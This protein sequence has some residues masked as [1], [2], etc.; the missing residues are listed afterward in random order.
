MRRRFSFLLG[1]EEKCTWIFHKLVEAS[2]P[3]EELRR[4]IMEAQETSS[5]T[6]PAKLLKPRHR[7]SLHLPHALSMEV[8]L[9][10]AI[11]IASCAPNCWASTIR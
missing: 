6:L 1:L 10:S 8:V 7:W 9:D 5:L 3:L 2:C 4:S 11:A